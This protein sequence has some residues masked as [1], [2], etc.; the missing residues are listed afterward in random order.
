MLKKAVIVT[1]I[2]L[3]GYIIILNVGAD[4]SNTGDKPP[5]AIL[6]IVADTLIINPQAVDLTEEGA[7]DWAHWGFGAVEWTDSSQYS[8]KAGID[9][10]INLD[11]II[12]TDQL[13]NGSLARVYWYAEPTGNEFSWTD[14]TP[15]ESVQNL[16][17]GLWMAGEGNGFRITVPASTEKRFLKLYVGAWEAEGR[18]TAT[19]SDNSA[20]EIKS[21]FKNIT[22]D[23]SQLNVRQYVLEYL[24]ASDNET[25][26]LTWIVREY[27]DEDG[28]GNVTLRAVALS[29]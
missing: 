6:K 15:T 11:T 27:Y 5:M 19:L 10:L 21:S 29:E 23:Y 2:L 8:H 7:L 4:H 17:A 22:N 13:I 28:W 20:S 16:D 25:L 26:T 14:G 3:V 18:L 12:V 9:P 1:A 24:A